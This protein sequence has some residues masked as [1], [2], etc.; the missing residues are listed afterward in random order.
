MSALGRLYRLSKE[1]SMP[2]VIKSFFRTVADLFV[3]E[4]GEL[5]ATRR[6][7][8]IQQ[9]Q[10]YARLDRKHRRGIQGKKSV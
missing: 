10:I 6:N 3:H 7:S 9:Q 8:H 5:L 1:T 2:R 4:S